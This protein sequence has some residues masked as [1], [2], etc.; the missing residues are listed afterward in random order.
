MKPTFYPFRVAGKQYLAVPQPEGSVHIIDANGNN[1]GGWYQIDE[2]KK[3][4]KAGGKAKIP[5]TPLGEC[6]LAI[7]SA[8]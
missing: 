5:A 7:V 8:C 1:Y 4:L 6:R 2:F 3:N